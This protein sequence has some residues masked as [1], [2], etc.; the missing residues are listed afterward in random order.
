MTSPFKYYETT[1]N[2]DQESLQPPFPISIP[3][4][5][6][7]EY[8]DPAS[9]VLVGPISTY[10]INLPIRITAPRGGMPFCCFSPRSRHVPASYANLQL[11]F[12]TKAISQRELSGSDSPHRDYC[13]H[14]ASDLHRSSWVNI[15]PR[16]W[17]PLPVLPPLSWVLV[18]GSFPCDMRHVETPLPSKESRTGWL[19]GVLLWNASSDFQSSH[20]L[21][22]PDGHIFP[23]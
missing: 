4:F 21:D 18:W 22:V 12:A 2:N 17:S 6:A 23:I 13:P 20:T 16:L 10:F 1:W 19:S 3:S 9:N 15:I 11:T 14:T 5:P 8:W 7:P